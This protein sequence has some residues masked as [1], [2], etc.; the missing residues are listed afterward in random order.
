MM[1]GFKG[2]GR[3]TFREHGPTAC[4]WRSAKTIAWFVAATERQY[5][6]RYQLVVFE[7]MSSEFWFLLIALVGF[8]GFHFPV[9]TFVGPNTRPRTK[10]STNKCRCRIAPHRKPGSR[11]HP[12][13]L[14]HRVR[15]RCSR[16][17]RTSRTGQHIVV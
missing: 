16:R 14:G 1:K 6:T 7:D 2:G 11:L 10:S 17:A 8:E 3:S 4:E 9:R 15:S 5:N 13:P 12:P